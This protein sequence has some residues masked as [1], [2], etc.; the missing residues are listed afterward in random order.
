MN[1]ENLI[2]Y[3][4]YAKQEGITISA[5]GYRKRMGKIKTKKVGK[6]AYVVMN[7]RGGGQTA[8]GGVVTQTPK[9]TDLPA[10]IQTEIDRLELRVARLRSALEALEG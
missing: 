4:K 8:S 7:G 10:L 1:N 9:Q 3:S 5:V 2:S 6:F